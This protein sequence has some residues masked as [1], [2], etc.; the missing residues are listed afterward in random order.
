MEHRGAIITVLE[1]LSDYQFKMF[2]YLAME[3]LYIERAEKEKIDRIDLAH[4]IS[5]QYLGTDYIEFM[6]RVT[7]FIPNK[8]YVDSLL[9]RAEADAEATMEAVTEAVTKAV[10]EEKMAIGVLKTPKKQRGVCR[11]LLF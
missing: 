5:E 11:K 10:T 7:D 1:N 4:K 9:A 3:D 8:V 6:K 2:I